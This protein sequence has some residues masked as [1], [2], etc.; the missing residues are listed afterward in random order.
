MLVVMWA[1]NNVQHAFCDAPAQNLRALP[2]QSLIPFLRCQHTICGTRWS[3]EFLDDV[4]LHQIPL[5]A[6]NHFLGAELAL[7]LG[8]VDR[9]ARSL[10]WKRKSMTSASGMS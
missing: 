10:L 2:A 4:L 5:G 3:I 9:T 7:M 8:V 1:R 6:Q